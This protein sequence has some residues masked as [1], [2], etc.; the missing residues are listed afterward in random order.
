MATNLKWRPDFDE[1]MRLDAAIAKGAPALTRAEAV[2]LVRGGLVRVNDE[3]VVKPALA[4]ASGDIV[5]VRRHSAADSLPAPPPMPP[6]L[7]EDEHLALVDKPPYAVVHHGAGRVGDTL[8]D[9]FK[10]HWRALERVGERG[11]NG[12]VHR[13][14]KDTSGIL[15]VALSE[16]ACERLKRD[17]KARLIERA[18]IALVGGRLTPAAGVIDAPLARD[19]R[20]PLRRAAAADGKPARTRYETVANFSSTSL[21]RLKLESGRTHQIRA[22]LAAVGHPICGDALYGGRRAAGLERQF[23]HAAEIKLRHPVSRRWIEA[24]SELP[25]DLKR[26]LQSQPGAERE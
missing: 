19:R 11:R 14:D 2:K 22:H 15:M 9:A 8:A 25:A 23:L 12:I 18:Y 20:N 1:R 5:Q 24:K 4:L 6:I 26:A 3:L 21:L 16:T 10:L 13:L 7:Y 17:I